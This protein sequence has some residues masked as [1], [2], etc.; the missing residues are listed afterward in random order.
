M[1]TVRLSSGAAVGSRARF[2]S[3]TAGGICG[4]IFL[5]MIVIQNVLEL[6]FSLANDASAAEILK[7][8][9][10]DAWL[11][12]LTFVTFVIGFPALFYF[13]AKLTDR[14]SGAEHPAA[15]A[16][17]T[18]GRMAVVLVAALFGLVN[19]TQVLIVADHDQLAASPALTTTLWSLHN[20]LFTLNLAA[21]GLM[22]LG[23]SRA[24][25]LSRIIPRWLG[26]VNV[27]GAALLLVSAM[28]IVTQVHGSKLLAVGAIGFITWM[29][30][31][32]LAGIGLIRLGR[33]DVA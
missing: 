1:A 24:A 3:T 16:W 32:L 20:A 5:L 27:V 31:L 14:A 17:G 11:V 12:D 4:L 13:A 19:L 15:E 9:Q 29:L 10:D 18:F 7:H 22:L 28:P 25:A 26:R 21:V 30:F 2:N 8:F 33:R 6:A 23:L